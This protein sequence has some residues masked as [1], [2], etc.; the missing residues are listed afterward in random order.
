[1]TFAALASLRDGLG[2]LA[3]DGL[4][5]HR[6]A[7]A[8]AQGPHILE[9]GR[10]LA[11]FASNDYLGLANHP[12]VRAAATR[13]IEAHG[14]G[15]GAS[16]LVVGHS[17]L[18]DEAESAFARFVGA[19]RALLFGS[20]YA[21]NLGIL[22]ALGDR[23]ADIFA[24][25]LNHACLNDGAVLARANLKRYPHA[26]LD[27]LAA[28]LAA[29]TA[30][31]KIIATDTV[32]SMDG[33]VA[34]VARL[35][36]LAEAHDAWLVLDDAHGIGVLGGG[37][38][39]L[40]EWRV[41]SPRIICMATIGKALGGYGAFVSAEADVIEWLL[42]RARTYVFSTALPPAMAAAAM[43]ALEIIE[44]EP[45]RAQSLH[46]NINAFRAGC[47]A[48]GI[49]TPSRTAI[50]PVIVGASRA[51]V[52]LAQAL[53]DRGHWVPAIRPPTVPDG[54][55]RLRVSLCAEHNR[56]DIDRLVAD[57]AECLPARPEPGSG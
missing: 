54:T 51:A 36:Q 17:T 30:R 14:F 34:D 28:M 26:D 33:D 42:Q 12:E 4:L 8:S 32:F 45:E 55:A 15:A 40:A 5:R 39:T 3:R 25:R 52:A 41:R 29:S 20:G 22:A 48:A 6:R 11:N 24:D 13:A 21:A 27:R 9:Q 46:A 50:H 31:K 35:A 44:R 16:P 37:R 47:A 57:L 53:Q 1:M 18:H 7:V 10:R 56:Q 49:D 2:A 43:A 19:P 38:G 23:E